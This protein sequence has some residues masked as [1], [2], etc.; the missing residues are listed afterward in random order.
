MFKPGDVVVSVTDEKIKPTLWKVKHV[1][2]GYVTADAM[3]D[4]FTPVTGIFK[5][6]QWE[7]AEHRPVSVGGWSCDICGV[8]VN[9]QTDEDGRPVQDGD[10]VRHT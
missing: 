8:G 2:G 7:Y 6:D 3:A 10:S 9:G 5:V 1:E 4:A